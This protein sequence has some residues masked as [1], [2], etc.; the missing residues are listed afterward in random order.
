M[1]SDGKKAVERAGAQHRGGLEQA[2]VSGFKRQANAAH[3]NRKDHHRGSQ[4]RALGGEGELDSGLSQQRADGAAP[5]QQHQEDKAHQ[6]R[7]QND[8][9]VGDGVEQQLARKARPRQSKG[10]GDG[11]RQ[12][13]QHGIGRH[14]ETGG[15]DLNLL[16]A[17]HGLSPM[18]STSNNGS[19]S[20]SAPSFCA[21]ASGARRIR[22]LA[23]AKMEI[24]AESWSSKARTV[25]RPWSSG[26]KALRR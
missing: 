22:A 2:A 17:Q 5:A 14:P 10:G 20:I 4:R 9:E 19:T 11:E 26:F 3:E 1:E 13:P 25:R 24:S 12:R 8:G 21:G 7:W 16:A 6:H 15:E 18:C 23:A